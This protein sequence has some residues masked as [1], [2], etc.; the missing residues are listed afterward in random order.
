MVPHLPPSRSAPTA[1]CC[2]YSS[3]LHPPRRRSEKQ[4]VS[5]EWVGNARQP[6]I[7]EQIL[8][9]TGVFLLS[10]WLT[11]R[12][13]P[14]QGAEAEAAESQEECSDT[15]REM[16]L[17]RSLPFSTVSKASSNVWNHPCAGAFTHPTTMPIS[18]QPCIYIP[19]CFLAQE[20]LPRT[21]PTPTILLCS[22]CSVQPPS[23]LLSDRVGHCAAL[24][25]RPEPVWGRPSLR[26]IPP[27]GGPT[28][29]CIYSMGP[30]HGRCETQA[31]SMQ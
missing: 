4:G 27:A 16:S 25:C 30:G 15:Q 22:Q 11:P 1:S 13:V 10:S 24:T 8:F 26:N 21:K 28:P 31:D 5:C 14:A 20:M 12:P 3:P 7:H 2:G 29:V 19:G 23:A 9:L 18:T 17:S 6:H